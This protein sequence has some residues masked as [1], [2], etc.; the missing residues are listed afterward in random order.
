MWLKTRD[1]SYPSLLQIIIKLSGAKM[2]QNG[3]P[4]DGSSLLKVISCACYETYLFIRI[5]L[6]VTPGEKDGVKYSGVYSSMCVA[7]SRFITCVSLNDLQDDLPC[8]QS[9]LHVRCQFS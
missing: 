9:F 6:G 5:L 8:R 3:N 2:R 4:I 7:R 1:S